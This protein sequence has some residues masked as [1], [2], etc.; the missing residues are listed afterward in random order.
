MSLLTN[1]RFKGFLLMYFVLNVLVTYVVTT[2]TFNRYIVTFTRTPLTELSSIIGNIAVLTIILVIGTFFIKKERGLCGYM[3]VITFLLNLLM[4][5]AGYFTRNYKTMFS[6]HNI[7]L[8][9]NPDAGFASR[10]VIDALK[11]LILYYRIICFIPFIAMLVYYLCMQKA[12]KHKYYHLSLTRKFIILLSALIMSISSV[13]YFRYKLNKNWEYRTE[14]PQYG[15]QVCGIY[16]YFFAE[17]FYGLNYSNNYVK[18]DI[19]LIEGKLARFDKNKNEYVNII[20]GVTY[21]KIDSG[22]LK[23]KNLYMIQ[24]ESMQSFL[25]SQKYT[26]SEGNEKLLM[27]YMNK[28]LESDNAFFF[29]NAYTVVGLGNTSDAE[30]AVNTGFLPVGDMTIAW[31]AYDHDFTMHSLAKGFGNSYEKYSYN[32]TLEDFYAHKFD[33]ENLYGFDL[34]RGIESYRNDYPQK[35]NPDRYLQKNWVS[36][37]YMLLYAMDHAK[38]A[39][40]NGNHFYSFVETISPHLPFDDLS[41]KYPSDVVYEKID[42]TEEISDQFKNYMNQFHYNDKVMYDV[43]MKAQELLP[44]SVFVLYGDHGNTLEKAYYQEIVGRELTDLEYRRI[45]LNVPIIFYDPTGTLAKYTKSLDLDMDKI[46]QKVCSQ[47]DIYATINILFGLENDSY[48]FGTNLFSNEPSFA[49][50]PKNLDLITDSFMYSLKNGEY[51]KSPSLSKDEMMAI[52]KTIK[53]YKLY[54][55]YYLSYLV[56]NSPKR[57]NSSH[58][59][60]DFF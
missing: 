4:F 28:L 43:I 52:V 6:L 48:I 26:D 32:P 1:K 60:I 14:V 16:N 17:I 7:T 55:D 3:L 15:C 21:K 53:E 25:L 42:F 37:E 47:I 12:Y 40:D 46:T 50:D 23:G 24:V 18:D 54:S 38:A 57:E 58:F 30:F 5:L 36:D 8:F 51:M 11:E 41:D 34:F 39:L 27:P 59:L 2:S 33:H 29:S 9:R 22:I 35:D 44:N 13:G 45:L 20:D 31:E 19:E 10:V 49:I 56:S